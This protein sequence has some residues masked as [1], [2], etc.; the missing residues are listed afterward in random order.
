MADLGE[1]E[2]THYFTYFIKQ[3]KDFQ[4][5]NENLRL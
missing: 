1:K 5:G 4:K 3:K 2:I